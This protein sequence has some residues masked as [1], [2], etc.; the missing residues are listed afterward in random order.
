MGD[1]LSAASLFLAALGM[2]YGAWYPEL[3]AAHGVTVRK[4]RED[5]DSEI[6]VVRSAIWTRS[7][8]LAVACAVVTIALLPSFVGLL[9]E[10]VSMCRSSGV[11]AIHAYDAVKMLFSVIFCV[12]LALSIHLGFVVRGL[13]NKLNKLKAP[14]A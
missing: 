3:R 12:M 6:E 4:F 14:S 9:V 2:M 5:R 13:V 11:Q 8:P 10:A 7:L 1:L